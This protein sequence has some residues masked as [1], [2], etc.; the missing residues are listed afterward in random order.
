[1]SLGPTKLIANINHYGRLMKS[2]ISHLGEHQ[3]IATQDQGVHEFEEEQECVYGR[4]WR[5]GKKR[6]TK[7]N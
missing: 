6:I 2:P 1:M 4:I 7:S 3:K 5:E